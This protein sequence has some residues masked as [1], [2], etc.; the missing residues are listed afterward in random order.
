MGKMW[1]AILGVAVMAAVAAGCSGSS[2]TAPSTPQVMSVAGTWTGNVTALGAPA[3]LQWTV[4]QS[5]ASVSGP[6]LVLLPTGTV[7]VNGT[8]T[9]TVSNLTFTYSIAIAAGGI[10]SLP[11]CTGQMDGSV[12]G[13][14]IAST[15]LNGTLNLTTSTCPAAI[16]GA[17]IS[18]VK[19][20]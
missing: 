1:R 3:L 10:P 6:A 8:L 16:A 18:M 9:G 5:G 20:G 11:L 15:T 2:G 12:S 17:P 4:T 14:T 7:L 19:T 13:T